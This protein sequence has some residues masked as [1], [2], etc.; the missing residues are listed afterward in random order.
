M[1]IMRNGTRYIFREVD[2]EGMTQQEVQER[3]DKCGRL[4]YEP[5][6]VWLVVPGVGY[7]MEE[8]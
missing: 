4:Q 6:H 3:A 8:R 5:N 2:V 7:G 1:I